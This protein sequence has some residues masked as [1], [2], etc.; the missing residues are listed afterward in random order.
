M[1]HSRTVERPKALGRRI[2]LTFAGLIAVYAG[3]IVA[4]LL[5]GVWGLL[6]GGIAALLVVLQVRGSDRLLLAGL[7]AV[8]V[9]RG[10]E[11]ELH[12]ILD[13]LCV[14]ADL[15]GP[16][17]LRSSS[18]VPNALAVGGL[19][20]RASICVDR[21]LIALLEPAELEGV[22]AHELAHV[23]HRDVV[24]MTLAGFFSLVAALLT[25]LAIHGGHTVVRGPAA[26]AAPVA[27]LLSALLI[28]ALSRY[29]ELAADQTAAALTGRPS[30]LASALMKT[31]A[32]IAGLPKEDLRK[33][34]TSAALA[35]A[36]LPRRRL[37]AVWATHPSTE[38][39]VA[40]LGALEAVQQHPAGPRHTGR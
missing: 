13:R 18:G 10:Q 36:P 15:P 35:F 1:A 17:V 32:A 33:V 3:L 12:A 28:R 29:R 11:P 39:R 26:L 19:G 2:V 9:S 27:W 23:A 8:E 7:G 25:K 21:K 5:S 16:R 34:S 30:A 24:V 31:D 20:G 38:R 40:A 22:V 6:V 4:L 14:Q 37:A